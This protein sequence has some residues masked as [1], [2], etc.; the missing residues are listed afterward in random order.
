MRAHQHDFAQ[1]ILDARPSDAI[2]LAL[3]SQAPI[4]MNKK[5]LYKWGVPIQTVAKE[6][7][8]GTAVIA[9]YDHRAKTSTMISEP[10]IA[11]ASASD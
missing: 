7:E 11:H 8:K 5:L 3:Q 9:R 1:V 6:V 4:F 2:V 10:L